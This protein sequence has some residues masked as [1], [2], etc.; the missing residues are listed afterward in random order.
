[1][2]RVGME[3]ERC[4]VRGL[5]PAR[6]RLSRAMRSA[7]AEWSSCVP[8]NKA[9]KTCSTSG[10]FASS[11]SWLLVQMNGFDLNFLLLVF[12]QQ[13]RSLSDVL[14]GQIIV[15]QFSCDSRKRP[16]GGRNSQI[17][18]LVTI[19]TSTWRDPCSDSTKR[20]KF[21]SRCS[22]KPMSSSPTR[23]V[24]MAFSCAT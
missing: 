20:L 3:D 14:G 16:G 8:L 1:M 9:L 12:C 10:V 15:E 21:T 23:A 24:N 19:V 5:S 22:L 6:L 17:S 13:V 7:R 2:P 4:L 18:I 11:T